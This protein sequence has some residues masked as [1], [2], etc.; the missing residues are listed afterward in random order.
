MPS[1]TPHLAT[2]REK[3]NDLVLCRVV[4]QVPNIDASAP[5]DSLVVFLQ[6]HTRVPVKVW[7]P[8]VARVQVRHRCPALKAPPRDSTPH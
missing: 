3:I 7:R 2:P 5:L 1:E 4:G 8:L 6:R